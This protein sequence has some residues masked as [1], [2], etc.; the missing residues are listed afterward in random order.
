MKNNNGVSMSAAAIH[1]GI[2]VVSFSR[3][4]DLGVIQ[5]QERGCYDLTTCRLARLK[6]LENLAAG[7]SGPDG[8]A[9]LA[10]ERALL[11]REQREA[12]QIKNALARGELVH[13]DAVE[14]TLTPLFY[15]FREHAL[16]T[17]GKIADSVAAACGGDRALVFRILD[18]QIREMLDDLADGKSEAVSELRP[19]RRRA[20]DIKERVP[21]D[22]ASPSMP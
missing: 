15:N 6:H 16:G 13:L 10:K 12:A 4:L 11:A 1:L 22:R 19:R 5:R 3:L 2:S 17:P 14:K 8:G 20:D 18:D 21:H 7:R 9:L